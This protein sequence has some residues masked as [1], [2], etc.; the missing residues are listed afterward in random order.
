M[1]LKLIRYDLRKTL[2]YYLPILASAL[3]YGFISII[4]AMLFSV[5]INTDTFYFDALFAEAT[6]YTILF[7]FLGFWFTFIMMSA[8]ASTVMTLTFISY[9]RDMFTGRGYHLF[10][11]PVKPSHIYW[12]KLITACIAVFSVD[13]I[14]VS[15]GVIDC[16]VLLSSI[17]PFFQELIR[18]FI[19]ELGRSLYY[20]ALFSVALILFE[21]FS[22]ILAYFLPLF[23][24]CM[25][26]RRKTLAS[27]LW[28]IGGE[29]GLALILTVNLTFPTSI[30]PL[31]AGYDL[32]LFRS[33]LMITAPVPA[34]VLAVLCVVLLI[35]T[36]KLMS[37][38]HEIQ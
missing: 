24:Y 30:I 7:V 27:I 17:E 19:S 9:Y 36:I 22:I 35:G 8:C 3:G 29:Y 18:M 11:L 6:A 26:K 4:L 14:I 1:L 38:K 5:L 32:E 20:T 28:L 25:A 37:R 33:I 12:A 23:G 13:L 10:S 21:L 16:L 15:A 34:I 31:I 2:R